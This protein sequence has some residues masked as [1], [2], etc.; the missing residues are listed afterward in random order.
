MFCKKWAVWMIT[1]AFLPP[2]AMADGPKDLE[3]D[4]VVVTATRT[5]SDLLRLPASA[6]RLEGDA[7]KDRGAGD[8]TDI[9][10][11]LP[12]VDISG[13]TGH[14][15]QPALR[16][17]PESQT[18]IKIDGARENYVQKAGDAQTT[19]LLDPDLL[20]AV[21]V[22][23]GPAS[24]L[25]GGGGIGG[26]I[27]FTTKDAADLLR[28][29]QSFG[30]SLRAGASTADSSRDGSLMAYGRSG[31]A[32]LLAFSSYRD[33]GSYTS[34]DPDRAK[35]RLSG[36]R[37]QH[38]MKASWI[39][40]EGRR[41][42]F[43]ASRYEQAYKYPDEGSWYE[44]EQN[45]FLAALELDPG[46]QWVD[47]RMTLMHSE[48]KEDQFNN[49]RNGLKFT[50]SGVDVQNAMRFAAGPT[51]HRVVVG[52]DFYKDE[53][54]PQT[55]SWADPP[56]EGR[57]GGLF[58]Q[59]E[60]ALADGKILIISG[61]RYTWFD[62]SGKRS[63]A[64]DGSDSRLNPRVSL[65]WN[66]LESL[67]FYASYA[68]AFRPPLVSEMY[69]ELDFMNPPVHI[70]VL[71]NPDLKPETAKTREFG[72]HVSRNGLFSHRDALRFKAVWFIEDIEDLISIKTLKD[73]DPPHSFER[74]VQTVNIESAKRQ[75]YELAATYGIGDFGMLFT[76]AKVD[77]RESSDK[78]SWAGATPGVFQSRIHYHFVETGLRLGW[79]G[80]FVE[81][82]KAE[83]KTW[84]SHNIHGLFARWEGRSGSLDGLSAGIFVDNLL[85]ESYRAYHFKDSG[86]GIGRNL[87]VSFGYRF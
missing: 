10:S 68:E 38:L 14:S 82:F 23:R 49:V 51:R 8:I 48:R 52:G 42:S 39:P 44:S 67:G 27:A 22:V 85:D 57:D 72:M 2:F 65:S 61:L 3:M 60:M 71:A 21:E 41:V 36:D 47:T 17:L 15:R 33:Y 11:T 7:L 43:S 45:R 24:T 84:E 62:R 81:S 53:Y 64:G 6:D 32:D 77:N 56:G 34:S 20:K 58:I 66:P 46:S 54:A 5:E 40:D 59:D 76:Y 55:D 29:G 25:H 86:A 78:D 26:V 1:L 69:T 50:S 73:L 80:R 16:G 28:P 35:T 37:Q 79:H 70:R 83:G 13:G 12:G 87:R 63:D 75:G 9:L 74:I 18:I 31:D 19:I 4:G 30:A